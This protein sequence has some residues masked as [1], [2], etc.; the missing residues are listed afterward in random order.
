[1]IFKYKKKNKF[2]DSAIWGLICFRP[3]YELRLPII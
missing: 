2:S 1:M 3:E